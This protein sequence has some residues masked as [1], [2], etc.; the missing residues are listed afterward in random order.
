MRENKPF[1]APERWQ[2]IPQIIKAGSGDCEDLSAW[3]IAELRS[4]GIKSWPCVVPGSRTVPGKWH[5]KVYFEKNGKRYIVDPSR[6][7]GM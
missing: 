7:L 6:K 4:R 3:L 2:T 5:I 1:G